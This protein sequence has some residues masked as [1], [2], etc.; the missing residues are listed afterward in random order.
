[1]L[2]GHVQ[3]FHPE[4]PVQIIDH[5]NSIYLLGGAAN[6]SKNIKS[7]ECDV[8]LCGFIGDD[9]YSEKV[10]KLLNENKIEH[11]LIKISSKKHY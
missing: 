11:C 7:L 9:Y 4:A 1:M 10:I 8:I 6:V 5:I 3:E 2:R